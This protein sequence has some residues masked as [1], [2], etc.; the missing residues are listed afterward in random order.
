MNTNIEYYLSNGYIMFSAVPNNYI[1]AVFKM[2]CRLF[3]TFSD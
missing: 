3:I 2:N 1:L